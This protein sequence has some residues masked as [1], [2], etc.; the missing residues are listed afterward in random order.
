VEFGN[1]SELQKEVELV[2]L[3]GTVGAMPDD[4]YYL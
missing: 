3:V 4:I 2:N 1:L